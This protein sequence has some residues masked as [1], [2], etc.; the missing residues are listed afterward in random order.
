M[1]GGFSMTDLAVHPGEDAVFDRN[2]GGAKYNY[3]QTAASVAVKSTT[4]VYGGYTVVSATATGVINIRNGT[5]TGEIVDVIPASTAAGTTKNMNIACPLG[6]Y[7]EFVGT[8][9]IN[10]HYL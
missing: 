4:A 8:G 2:W 10:V 7:A 9:T 5:V 3:K 1:N 6:L